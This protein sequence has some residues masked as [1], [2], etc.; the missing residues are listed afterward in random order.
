M[1][2]V[3]VA[4]LSGCAGSPPV[5]A[6]SDARQALRAAEDDMEPTSR[7][8]AEQLLEQA[9]DALEAEEYWQARQ[10]ADE[11]RRLARSAVKP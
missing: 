6:M 10:W 9:R 3:V 1:A 11:A 5:Q 8:R 2:G 7:R 4:A